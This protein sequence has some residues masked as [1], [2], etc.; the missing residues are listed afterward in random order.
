MYI[1]KKSLSRI[2]IC[3]DDQKFNIKIVIDMKYLDPSITNRLEIKLD[4]FI[5]FKNLDKGA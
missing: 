4:I 5:N 1:D 2:F 3:L